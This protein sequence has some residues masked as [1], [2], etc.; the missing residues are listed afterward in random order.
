QDRTREHGWRHV[1]GS[2][3]TC[4]G[5]VVT[6]RFLGFDPARV[7]KRCR[8]NEAL[9]WAIVK[10]AGARG[11]RWLDVGGLDRDD[12]IKLASG[13]Q[14]HFPYKNQKIGLGGVPIVYPEPL[15]LI[16]NPVLR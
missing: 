12:A 7:P 16:R 11:Y 6:G 14:P 2:C 13:V 15:E 10:W 3:V 9:V 4:F 5:E 1:A 8:P